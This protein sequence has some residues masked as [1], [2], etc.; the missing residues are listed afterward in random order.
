MAD[1]T[2]EPVTYLNDDDVLKRAQGASVMMQGIIKS[3]M[4]RVAD[5]IGEEKDASY[6][7]YKLRVMILQQLFGSLLVLERDYGLGPDAARC[8]IDGAEQ[9]AVA[10]IANQMRPTYID[11]HSHTLN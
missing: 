8:L 5:E 3:L 7:L 11:D 6:D 1:N 10:F 4:E 2:G 9:V